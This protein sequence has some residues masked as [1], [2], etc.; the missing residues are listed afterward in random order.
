MDHDGEQP[1]GTITTYTGETG[2]PTHGCLA[3]V[4]KKNVPCT[5]S[6]KNAPRAYARQKNKLKEYQKWTVSAFDYRDY[7]DDSVNVYMWYDGHRGYDYAVER[8]TPVYAS[9]RG[10][11]DNID[12]KWGQVTLNHSDYGYVYQTTYTHMELVYGPYPSV[13]KKGF[14]LGWVSNVAPKDQPVGAHLHFVVKK[15]VGKKW[16]V[17]DP[18][19]GSGE[20]RLWE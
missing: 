15:K 4:G 1:N 13:V 19:G 9:A 7:V 10:K 11:L 5:N 6:N 3:Y 20:P 16:V 12:R 18:Y 14:L 2:S 17:V 8:W